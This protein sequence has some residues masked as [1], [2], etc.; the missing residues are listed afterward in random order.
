MIF[1]GRVTLSCRR[2][3]SAL[4]RGG[5]REGWGEGG[6]GSDREAGGGG[7]RA[8][9]EGSL[10]CISRERMRLRFYCLLV[11]LLGFVCAPL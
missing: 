6:G 7:P 3:T 5:E 11:V 10:C 1:R 8:R 4:G 9:G 2:C